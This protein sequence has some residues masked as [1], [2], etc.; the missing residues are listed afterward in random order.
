MTVVRH[1]ETD[2][3]E[4]LLPKLVSRG[5]SYKPSYPQPCYLY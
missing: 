2:Y 1:K 5:T 4:T 3:S